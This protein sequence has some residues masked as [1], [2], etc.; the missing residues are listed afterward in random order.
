MIRAGVFVGVDQTGGGLRT[1]QDAAAGATAMRDLA[2]A[3]GGMHREH[4]ISITDAPD[5]DGK[6]PPVT[7]RAVFEAVDSLTAAPVRADFLLVY[8]SGHGVTTKYQQ[9]EQWLLS[10]APRD[11]NE[12]ISVISTAACARLGNVP[13]VCIISDACRL[14]AGPDFPVDGGTAYPWDPTDGQPRRVVDEF[15]SCRFGQTSAEVADQDDLTNATSWY[16]AEL[17]E[18]LAGELPNWFEPRD[19]FAYLWPTKLEAYF[20]SKVSRDRKQ[21]FLRRHRL[22][23][24]DLNQNPESQVLSKGL[25]Y[26]WLTRQPRPAPPVVVLPPHRGLREVEPDLDFDVAIG[27]IVQEGS[28]FEAPAQWAGIDGYE[29]R[30][31]ALVPSGPIDSLYDI[32]RVAQR[33]MEVAV[34]SNPQA[35][36]IAFEEA[37]R[38]PANRIEEFMAM[39]RRLI[40]SGDEI[41]FDTGTGIGV[42]G[43]TIAEA[44]GPGAR[45]LE[46]L[47]QHRV[48]CDDQDNVCVAVTLTNGSVL[49]IPVFPGFIAHLTVG[50][51]A[52]LDVAYEPTPSSACW[53]DFAE[54]KQRLRAMRA[55]AAATVAHTRYR[56]DGTDT[57][58]LVERM[59]YG[60]WIDP[61]LA[62]YTSY[63][64]YESLDK[65]RL[66]NV[67]ERLQATLGGQ[68]YDV[69]LVRGRLDAKLH[70]ED[71]PAMTGFAP[72]LSCGWPLLAAFPTREENFLRTLRP[73]AMASPW[74]VFDREARS[75]VVDRVSRGVAQ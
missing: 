5:G 59:C 66:A 7:R 24:G 32:S 67:A 61:T 49:A 26:E 18:V 6:R 41:V 75:S 31:G 20:A 42:S 60:P 58:L 68:F 39:I 33:L 8:F 17:L 29:S 55:I 2:V 44:T 19:G 64:L 56:L 13:Y 73:A 25:D 46:R 4:A 74:T 1:L 47:D 40:G 10:G 51:S 28:D 15:Y 48:R 36:E 45:P 3:C 50:G 22:G 34:E 57:G 37:A 72:L 43:A 62:L 21:A 54:H 27:D 52:V 16:T 35:L 30:H 38:A 63:P 70:P 65:D 69:L 23:A 14:S 53:G 12:A 11:P 9:D 71:P